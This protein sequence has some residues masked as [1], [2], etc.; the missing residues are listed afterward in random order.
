MASP[1]A[2]KI[3]IEDFG[4]Q[5]VDIESK[6]AYSRA[7][8]ETVNKLKLENPKDP[9]IKTL[10]D[11]VRPSKKRTTKKES[12]QPKKT[13][14]DAIKFIRGRGTPEP[15]EPTTPTI[16]KFGGAKTGAALTSISQTVNTI[17]K[18]VTR[19]NKFEKE[20]VSDTR[21]AREKKKRSMAENLIEGGKK[22]YGKVANTFG[23]VLK[24][25][26]GI[27]ESIFGFITKF[28]LGAA[29]MKILDWF[30]NPDNKDKIS[31]IFRF[32]KDFW[33]VIAA[34]VIALMGP[35]PSFVAAIAL[36]FGFV[37]KIIDFV[38]SI[39]GLNKD[40]DKEIKK[41]EKDYEKN[42]KGTAFDTDTE[43]KEQQVK[44]E[45]TPPE[46]QDAE[47]MNKGGMVPD[48]GNVTKMNKGGEVPGQGNTDTVPAM[49]TPGEFVLTKEAVKKVGA[50]TLYGINA[51]AGG[52]G[53]SNDV[54]RG[55]SGKP[56][57]KKSTV[58]TMMDMGG[59]NPINNISKSM[60]NVTNNTS[61]DMSKS[62]SNVTNNTSND[63][64]KSISN[65]TNNSSS[66]VTNNKSNVTNNSSS[67]VTNNKS[68]VIN[69]TIKTMNMSSGG[70]T[71]NMS[72]MGGGGMTKNSYNSGGMVTN[73]IGGTSNTQYMKLGGMV[74]NF[75][76]KT[77]QARLIKFAAKQIKKS[78]VGTPVS[79]VFKKL[80]TLGAVPPAP[81]TDM[82]GDPTLSGETIPKFSVI[83][84][85][86]R[87]KEQTLGV[88]R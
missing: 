15:V 62:M 58:Q 25:V 83:A 41:E 21:E 18:L 68:K 57:K 86:G 54:P 67:D 1:A 71:K 79:K 16:P 24:P 76:S 2:K 9:R 20:K 61:N 80:R 3:L 51:A 28:I 14:D 36:A 74:K 12:T 55:S 17:K 22:M 32:L 84:P 73:N 48:R 11:A 87:A 56:M 81:S 5:P 45:E 52:V 33:P 82:G 49:L 31:S 38:K 19:Q 85:G 34:G 44:P 64:S 6:S 4:Y 59:L 47:K 53:K 77:P 35:I 30:G 27:F 42:T 69:K 66:D 75:I 26:K 23:K 10:Q 65:V 50:D 60:S 46:Q 7:V 13:K 70:M 40:V 88:R 29:L 37:P 63:M 39:F 72:Y 8:R 78:P 43:E